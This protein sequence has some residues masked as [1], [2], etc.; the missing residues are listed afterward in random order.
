MAHE[1]IHEENLSHE[2]IMYRY[3]VQRG[4]DFTKIELFRSAREMYKNA[5]IYKP[6]DAFATEKIAE[7]NK[8]ISRDRKKVLVIVPVVLAI[9]TGI[10]LMNL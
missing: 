6:G 10:I 3:H 5:L 4:S 7:C 1:E 8:Y 9:I 2:E